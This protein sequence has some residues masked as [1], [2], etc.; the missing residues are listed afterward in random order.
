VNPFAAHVHLTGVETGNGTARLELVVEEIHLRPGGL[1]H[2]G[3]VAT[4]LDTVMGYAASSL[5]P[6]TA[7]VMTMQL[8]VNFTATGKLG[9]R[10]IVTANTIHAGRRTAVVAGE[11][12][13]PN[14]KLLA[15]ATATMFVVAEGIVT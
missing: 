14:G 8:N 10:V 3:M 6:D 5:V 9:E 1:M 11:I 7:D 4:M 13:L 15:A 2:G 12:R